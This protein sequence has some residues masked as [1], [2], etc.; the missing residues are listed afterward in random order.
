MDTRFTGLKHFWSCVAVDRP[1]TE[2]KLKENITLYSPE[3]DFLDEEKI[4][5]LASLTGVFPLGLV[6]TEIVRKKLE[7]YYVP[8]ISEYDPKLQLCWG[9]VREVECKKTK[10]GKDYYIVKLL[11]DSSQVTSVKCWGIQLQK[12]KLH[13][14]R[15]YMINPKYDEEWGFSTSGRV[16]N[17]WRLLG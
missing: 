13:V 7:E 3:G 10:N 12:D 5:Y 1:R 2:E 14:N 17:K 9:I 6:M 11:D 8:S 16:N 4:E 15:P